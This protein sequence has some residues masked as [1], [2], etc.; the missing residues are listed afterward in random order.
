MT[1]VPG[2]I[3]ALNLGK[4]YRLYA[5][6]AERLREWLGLGLRHRLHWALAPISFEIAPGESVG[7]VG[8]NGA[9]KSTLLKLIAGVIKNNT[10]QLQVGGRVC[11]LLELGLG[12][13]PE[14][15]GHDN[16]LLAGQLLGLTAQEIEAQRDWIVTFSGLGEAMHEPVRSYSSGMQ[17]RL[18]FALAVAKRPDVLIV[19]EALSVGDIFF[20]Q[21]CYELITRYHREGTTLLFVTHSMGAIQH[22]C[23]RALLLDQGQLILDGEPQA[24]MNLYESRGL[25]GHAK[26][27]VHIE[28]DSRLDACQQG[29]LRS[30]AI[31]LINIEWLN[32]D[33]FLIQHCAS[34]AMVRLRVRLAVQ[35]AQE[36]LHV[37]VKLRDKYGLVI[38]ET[39]TYCQHVTIGDVAAGD[40][41]TVEFDWV[42][43]V[44]EGM[45][46]ITLGIAKKGF[47]LGSFDEQL[48]YAHGLA[49]LEVSRDSDVPL[50]DGITNLHPRIAVTRETHAQGVLL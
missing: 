40:V 41:L 32:A 33:G 34:E 4:S 50:W 11:A 17:M 35:A 37:G 48:W 21:K 43:N 25:A 1:V 23:E 6:G 26:T 5:S 46:N 39:N 47:A 30:E 7:I 8:P 9:G 19:D 16:L 2:H 20:Q 10:G 12:F 13:D 42:L 44:R 45:Y 38:Y 3:S 27:A 31:D 28:Q 49:P 24:V 18:A 14:Q 29:S 36:D 22:L 15:S